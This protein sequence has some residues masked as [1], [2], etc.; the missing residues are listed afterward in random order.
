ML[1]TF[2]M[3]PSTPEA[4]VRCHEILGI[5]D[6]VEWSE[7]RVE[8][9]TEDFGSVTL[10]LMATGEQVRDLAELAITA[11]RMGSCVDS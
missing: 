7:M 11:N 5:P 9:G 4:Y 2:S 6:T 10:V 3:I 1:T 8:F